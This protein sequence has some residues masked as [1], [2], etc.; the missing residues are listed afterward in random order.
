MKTS[1]LRS[2]CRWDFFNDHNLFNDAF[3]EGILC[4]CGYHLA[5]MLKSSDLGFTEVKVFQK[6]ACSCLLQGKLCEE[7]I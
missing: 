5:M 7:F 1:V 2:L 6:T 4:S 3:E